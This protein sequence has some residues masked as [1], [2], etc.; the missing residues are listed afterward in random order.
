MDIATKFVSWNVPKLATLQSCKVYQLRKRLNS[1]EKLNR[2]EKNWLTEAVNHNCYFKQSVPC[3][4]YKFDFSDVLRHFWV[5]Q[6]GQ[7]AEY[8]AIDKTALR[9][10]LCGRIERIVELK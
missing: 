6:Y 4:G 10:F 8:Y 1:G 7:I 9:G 2:S 3:Q 5:S